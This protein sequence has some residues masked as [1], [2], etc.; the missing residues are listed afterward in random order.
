MAVSLDRVNKI[1]SDRVLQI[2]THFGLTN[3]KV[4][5]TGEKVYITGGNPKQYLQ[6]TMYILKSEDIFTNKVY[7]TY[8]NTLG[9]EV[10]ID[11]RAIHFFE[12]RS[13]VNDNLSKL[14]PHFGFMDNRAICTK[15]VNKIDS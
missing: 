12:I 4:E 2:P 11:T 6:Y 3:I 10:P 15:I 1:M 8:F 9:N 14:I 5:F 13:D 7:K